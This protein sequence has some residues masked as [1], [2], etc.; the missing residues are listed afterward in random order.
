MITVPQR[1]S[2]IIAL[3]SIAVFHVGILTAVAYAM[4]KN[5]KP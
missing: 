1:L 4:I 5:W 3:G 2:D